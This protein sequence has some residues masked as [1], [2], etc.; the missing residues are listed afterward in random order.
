MAYPPRTVVTEALNLGCKLCRRAFPFQNQFMASTEPFA[1]KSPHVWLFFDDA[2][3]KAIHGSQGALEPVN[4]IFLFMYKPSR[5]STV[6]PPMM[7]SVAYS[8]PQ[9]PAQKGEPER[10]HIML[11]VGAR[12]AQAG[13][14]VSFV[15]APLRAQGALLA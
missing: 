14:G 6:C 9:D 5:S 12:T 7:P 1:L 8:F 10:S 11:A 15:L 13:T 4:F 2:I 3:G